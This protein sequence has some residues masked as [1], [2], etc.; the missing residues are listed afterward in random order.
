[1]TIIWAQSLRGR[2]IDLIKPDAASIDFLEI[3]ETLSKINRFSGATEK[4][5]SVAQHTLIAADASDESL[6]PWVLLHDAHEAYI[7]DITTPVVLA[8]SKICDELGY[9]SEAVSQSLDELKKR[10]D[11]VIH[12]AAKISMPTATQKLLIRQCDVRAL[13]TERRDFLS[14]PPREW[15]GD[16]NTAAP[17]KNTYRYRSAP[18]MAIALYEQFCRYL[19]ALK[20]KRP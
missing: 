20:G 18:D 9:V 12:Q 4:P 16:I 15:D 8:L 14:K 2:A 3:A 13:K 6:K 1:M 19:P 5:I 11:I 17:L 10:H 7:G